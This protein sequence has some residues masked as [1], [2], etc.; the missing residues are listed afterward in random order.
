MSGKIE[1]ARACLELY[2]E[3]R[4]YKAQK[5]KDGTSVHSDALPL[6]AL[7]PGKGANANA[8]LILFKKRKVK[9]TTGSKV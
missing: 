4:K 7:V 2:E 8:T 1:K 9:L 3:F 6:H 5:P